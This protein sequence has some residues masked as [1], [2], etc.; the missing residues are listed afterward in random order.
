MIMA[1][2]LFM[3]HMERMFGADKIHSLR[4]LS[5]VDPAETRAALQVYEYDIPDE[6]QIY[7]ITGPFFFGAASRFQTLIQE[8]MP[9]VLILRMR[10][11][12]VMDATGMNAFEDLIKRAKQKKSA[13]LIAG[14]QPQIERK[15]EKF[16]LLE[17]I[18]RSNIFGTLVEAIPFAADIVEM[19]LRA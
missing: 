18:G 17:L 1:S 8:H 14:I 16:G 6:V 4:H 11:V 2:F 5:S 7:E 13:V 10:N 3:R 15:L 19:E 12:P 9:Q